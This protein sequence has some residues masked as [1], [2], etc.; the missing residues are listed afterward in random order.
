VGGAWNASIVT[1]YLRLDGKTY[2]AQGL[3][4][5]INLATERGDFALLT[6]SVLVMVVI[7]VATNRLFW[8]RLF[9]LANKLR[10]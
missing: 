4:A 8:H 5:T 7:V 2:T 1:E 3:G 9:D 10:D 6:A